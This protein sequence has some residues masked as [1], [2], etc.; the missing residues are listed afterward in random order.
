MFKDQ[1]YTTNS[2]NKLNDILIIS[3]FDAVGLNELNSLNLLNRFDKKFI[4]HRS[5]LN[6]LLDKL[7]NEFNILELKNNRYFNYITDYYDTKDLSFY[8]AHHN[9]KQ[10]RY[11]VRTRIYEE[12][13]EQFLEIKFKNNKGF[14]QKKRLKLDSIGNESFQSHSDFLKKFIPNCSVQL[15]I[16]L[17]V[18]YKRITLINIKTQE[19][20]TI[21][22][23]LSY[24]N[25]NNSV[26]KDLVIIE[27]KYSNKKLPEYTAQI[28]NQ[29]N[30][31]QI[32][33]S[34]YCFG[35]FLTKPN[36]KYNRFKSR[37]LNII[38]IINYGK[39]YGYNTDIE[40]SNK[41]GILGFFN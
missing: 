10:T 25:S 24:G 21:D 31:K 9:K 2:S 33:L 6:Q 5:L 3:Q 40:L 13:K 22:F 30:A 15:E 12:T 1:I 14:T 32:E 35:I 29:V 18:E 37:Y 8:N 11:K 23:D 34:K 7:K 17:K 20:I 41:M 16:T 38:K 39:Y 28:F 27:H 19:K 26:I 4:I 36:I